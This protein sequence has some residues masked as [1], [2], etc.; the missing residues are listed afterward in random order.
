MPPKQLHSK[1]L[2]DILTG[3]YVSPPD[4]FKGEDFYEYPL[5]NKGKMEPLLDLFL[6]KED[7]IGHIR[8]LPDRYGLYRL[9]HIVKHCNMEIAEMTGTR[10]H[11]LSDEKLRYLVKLIFV[12]LILPF[13]KIYL[14]CE[15]RSAEDLAEEDHG[16][17]FTADAGRYIIAQ[18][19]GEDHILFFQRMCIFFR[20]PFTEGTVDPRGRGVKY[21]TLSQYLL[22]DNHEIIGRPD[23]DFSS[24]LHGLAMFLLD[25]LEWLREMVENC[26]D[27]FADWYE[28]YMAEETEPE[29]EYEDDDDEIDRDFNFT[30]FVSAHEPPTQCVTI[31]AKRAKLA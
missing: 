5:K 11:P 24:C 23:K 8:R 13:R 7:I 2:Y 28:D 20:T 31:A 19:C 10:S 12:S 16:G 27:V 29:S 3:G 21:A 25:D 15:D 26:K 17:V 4:F 18:K 6:E 14:D 22:E 9:E 1:L 30:D